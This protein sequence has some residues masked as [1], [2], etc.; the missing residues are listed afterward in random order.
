M[1]LSTRGLALISKRLTS[2]AVSHDKV[3]D[4]SAQIVESVE[5][6][7][8][9]L[10]T[11]SFNLD[12]TNFS[13]RVDGSIE[14]VNVLV[15]IGVST[16][17]IKQVLALQAG[18]K[19]SSVNWRELFRD[20]KIRGLDSSKVKLGVMDGHLVPEKV[21]EEELKGATVQR[22]QVH[23]ARNVMSKV[24]HKIGEKVVDEVRGIFYA[25]SEKRRESSSPLSRRTMIP[26]FPRQ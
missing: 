24:P 6:W 2:T 10:F 4:H 5:A 16:D 15:V 1:G 9:R 18:D 3:S 26:R 14:K 22:C 21:F 19:E 7:R 11:D 17:G 8:T 13:I 25:S 23:V 20:L 12:G